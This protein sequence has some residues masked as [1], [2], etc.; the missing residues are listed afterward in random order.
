MTRQK[1]ED[2]TVPKSRGNTALTRVRK[3]AT[4][5][6]AIPV[7]EEAKHSLCLMSQPKSPRKRSS[8]SRTVRH[9]RRTVRYAKPKPQTGVKRP[10]PRQQCDGGHSGIPTGMHGGF[11]HCAGCRFGSA[12]AGSEY[13]EVVN[14]PTSGLI[15]GCPE[16]P[17]V[18]STSTVL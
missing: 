13:V 6:R 15:T 10:S 9:R 12:F 18:N 4:G 3:H 17:Y 7:N 5:G 11:C 14:R 8:K 2:R 16:E 1:S